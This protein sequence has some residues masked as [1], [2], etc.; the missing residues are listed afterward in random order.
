MEFGV[1]ARLAD[2]LG[3]P[4]RP[5]RRPPEGRGRAR[6]AAR[7]ASASSTAA[8]T[9]CRA[10]PTRDGRPSAYEELDP[11]DARARP[12][13]GR[14]RG[15]P[16]R[17]GRQR[18]GLAVRRRLGAAL[19]AR[20]AV[21]DGRAL[22]RQPRAPDPAGAPARRRRRA[23]AARARDRR[24]AST[25][26]TRATPRSSRSSAHACSSRPARRP[27]TRSSEIRAH[28]RLHDPHAGARRQ[29]GVRRRA[30]APLRRRPRAQRRASPTTGCSTLGRGP[31]TD[32]FGL[33]PLALRLSAHRER[34]LRAARRASRA[35]CGAGSGPD[36]ATP[37]DAITN[38]VHLGTWLAPE[39]ADLLREAGVRPEA[40]PDVGELAGGARARPG[41]ALA[42]ARRRSRRRLA[43]HAGAR[44]GAAD[45]RLRA[46]VRDVQARR[47]SSTRISSGCSRCRCR[48][49]SPA[50]RIRRTRRA[51]T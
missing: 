46:P 13:A 1:D 7:R 50:R 49:S 31:D 15:R 33:T 48:S 26:S 2:L 38:G 40:P 35:R 29:R 14:R 18:R 22:L 10:S 44:S 43:E 4:R 11:E 28:D 36:E 16:R 8:A 27:T 23:R 25:T 17:R 41:R 47:R 34:R 5:R 20:R 12:R 19:S 32:G 21:G 45:D 42:R 39:L 51:R 24:R 6:R 37:I 3:R 9:S 30:R